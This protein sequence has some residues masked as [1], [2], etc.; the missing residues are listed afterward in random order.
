[1]VRRE[2]EDER[3]STFWSDNFS[4]SDDRI[5]ELK[6]PMNN[7]LDRPPGIKDERSPSQV[8][9]GTSEDE[10]RI[11]IG[12]RSTKYLRRFRKFRKGRT[13]RFS[14]T[15]HWPAFIMGF[16]WMFYRKLYGWG[17]LELLLS[18]IPGAWLI[19]RPIF[20]VT[21]NYLVF[22]R[23]TT[24]IVSLKESKSHDLSTLNDAIQRAGGIDS[25][26]PYMAIPLIIIHILLVAV[27]SSFILV[28]WPFLQVYFR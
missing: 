18:L 26:V 11:F 16:W 15:W 1:M 17:L 4:G 6:N 13:D 27:T 25:W 7:W 8:F 19:S 12:R 24:S 2:N 28:M 14:V 9:G 22:K 3:E 10:L 23:A 20:A 5:I 21:A